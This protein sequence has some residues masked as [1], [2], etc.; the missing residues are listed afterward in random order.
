MKKLLSVLLAALLLI[1]AVTTTAVPVVFAEDTTEANIEDAPVPE[2]WSLPG[3]GSV[4]NYKEFKYECTCGETHTGFFGIFIA[5]FH[6]I[7]AIFNLAT[8]AVNK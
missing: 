4:A 1:G 3:D 5:M 6:S 2:G 7:L 8:K